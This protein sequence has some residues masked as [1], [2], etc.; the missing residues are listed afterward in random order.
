MRCPGDVGHTIE[1]Q[2]RRT[3]CILFGIEYGRAVMTCRADSRKGRM[4]LHRT[5]EFFVPGFEVKSMQSLKII[6]CLVLAHRGGVNGS[7]R[8]SLAIDHRGGC[9][10]DF[11]RDLNTTAI[12]RWTLSCFQQSDAPELVS[13]ICIECIKAV[14]FRSSVATTSRL[15]NPRLGIFSWWTYSGSASTFP[16]T[17]ITN[18]FPNVLGF[19]VLR[20]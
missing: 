16:S 10:S 19:N 2:K 1:Q 4:N 6:A 20:S 7:V 14:V 11:R 5:A 18:S 17:G 12:V 15:R 8:T 9:D 3:L 13:G